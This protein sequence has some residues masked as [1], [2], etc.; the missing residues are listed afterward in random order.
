VLALLYQDG[1]AL[2]RYLESAPVPHLESA[3]VPLPSQGRSGRTAAQ[4]KKEG[5]DDDRRCVLLRVLFLVRWR[6]GSVPQVW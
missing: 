3:P 4:G 2:A 6:R 5:V 1:K